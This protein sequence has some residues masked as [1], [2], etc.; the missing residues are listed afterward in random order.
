M[1]NKATKIAISF[2]TVFMF[3]CCTKD[4]SPIKRSVTLRDIDGNTYKTVKIGGQ[5]WMAENLKVT[6]YRNGDA[7]PNVANKGEWYY[8]GIGA[9][10]N[11]DDDEG[12]VATY[13]RLYNWYAVDNICNIAPEGW[14]V[15]S[16]SEWEI[17]VNYLGGGR[18]AG[19]KMKETGFTHWTSPNTAATNESGFTALPGGYRRGDGDYLNMG[20]DAVFWTSMEYNST[21]A[22][23]RNLRNLQPNVFRGNYYKLGGY[24]IRCVKD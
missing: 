4:F 3:F 7:I 9:Y 17:L 5:L 20:D 13:G 1:S 15:P 23:F 12:N 6:H 22:W 24:S 2:F 16:E 8:F 14:H 18:V 19:G 21:H 10:C 11:Y